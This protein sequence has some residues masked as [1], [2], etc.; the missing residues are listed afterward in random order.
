[1][2]SAQEI[3]T[4]G[5]DIFG[6]MQKMWGKIH[7]RN[8]SAFCQRAML[9]R[10]DIKSKPAYNELYTR[11]RK[12]Y[13]HVIGRERNWRGRKIKEFKITLDSNEQVSMRL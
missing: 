9:H 12:N 7:M 8:G 13:G 4:K 3:N 2:H 5:C 11:L 10:S 1:M 6:S